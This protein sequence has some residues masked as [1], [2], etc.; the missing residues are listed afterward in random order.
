MRSSTRCPP[1]ETTFRSADTRRVRCRSVHVG[2]VHIAIKKPRNRPSATPEVYSPM[3]A[4]EPRPEIV[5]DFLRLDDVLLWVR[6]INS[7]GRVRPLQG[8][9]QGFESPMLHQGSLIRTPDPDKTSGSVWCSRMAPV[10]RMAST[11]KYPFNPIVE[12]RHMYACHSFEAYIWRH[13]T[14][15]TK[16]G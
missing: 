4:A 2:S 3:P 10:S 1:C 12:C 11:G 9:S 7:A 6:G 14:C 16:R 13:S 8:R 15:R 5:S